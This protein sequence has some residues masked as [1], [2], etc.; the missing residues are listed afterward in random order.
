[1]EVTDIGLLFHICCEM[2]SQ[3]KEDDLIV[4]TGITQGVADN[5]SNDFIN[6]K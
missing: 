4:V 6:T 3:H 5:V 1:M 2:T